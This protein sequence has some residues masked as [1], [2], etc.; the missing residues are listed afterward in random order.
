M[1]Y[2][3]N[4]TTHTKSEILDPLVSEWNFEQIE[5]YYCYIT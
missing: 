2:L 1:L 4:F 3:M 5:N